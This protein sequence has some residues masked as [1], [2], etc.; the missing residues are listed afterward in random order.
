MDNTFN[1][2]QSEASG[3]L[4]Q[5]SVPYSLA[6]NS[7]MTFYSQPRPVSNVPV[8][9]FVPLPP[10]KFVP[11]PVASQ[12]SATM[13]QPSV[14]PLSSVMHGQAQ[15]N[16]AAEPTRPIVQPRKP[17]FVYSE[18]T[19]AAQKQRELEQFLP[20]F[21]EKNI[22]GGWYSER[23]FC[24]DYFF[25]RVRG[26]N[27]EYLSI[28]CPQAR[29]DIYGDWSPF[30]MRKLQDQFNFELD[31]LAWLQDQF[32]RWRMPLYQPLD[33]ADLRPLEEEVESA[34]LDVLTYRSLKMSIVRRNPDLFEYTLK[35]NPTVNEKEVDVYEYEHKSEVP[36]PKKT[37]IIIDKLK[38]QPQPQSKDEKED[39][40]ASGAMMTICDQ[41]L[42]TA[43]TAGTTNAVLRLLLR[44]DDAKMILF[45]V[46]TKQPKTLQQIIGYVKNPNYEITPETLNEFEEIFKKY[47]HV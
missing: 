46:A 23:S 28:R 11:I 12:Q 19:L 40:G 27:L 7:S 41:I 8:S 22:D 47:S 20:P 26:L 25:N 10:L 4:V 6:A 44:F 24:V 35:D 3:P 32:I 16:L 17:T 38:K 42:K 45:Q 13:S 1:A 18:K 21:A 31:H 39:D 5:S 36:T 34:V 14:T 33:P 30:L 29:A 2:E 43:N 37:K 9:K 15:M